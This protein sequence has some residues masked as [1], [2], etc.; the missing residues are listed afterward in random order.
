MPLQYPSPPPQ[1]YQAAVDNL[2]RSQVGTEDFALGG[3]PEQV[4]DPIQVFTLTRPAVES[5]STLDSA[6]AEGWRYLV[7]PSQPLAVGGGLAS[8]IQVAEV[9]ETPDGHRF[10]HRQGGWLGGRTRQ[11]MDAIATL[12]QVQSGN[13]QVRML[14][15]PSVDHIDALWLKN[16]GVGEDLVVPI[17]ST[18]PDLIAGRP[19]AASNFLQIVRHSTE[20]PS[21][22]NSPRIVE[23]SGAM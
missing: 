13:Y 6:T 1:S 23:K 3:R 14:R 4:A 22:D 11:T 17:A 8:S 10:S 12:P 5:A 21:F 16:E 18:N 2:R 19:L 9:L 15:L 7:K 20:K